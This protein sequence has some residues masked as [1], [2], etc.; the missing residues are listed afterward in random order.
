MG[1]GEAGSGGGVQ[2]AAGAVEVAPLRRRG[3]GLQAAFMK[4]GLEE[5][6]RIGFTRSLPGGLAIAAGRALPGFLPLRGSRGRLFR[7]LLL[8]PSFRDAV[9]GGREDVLSKDHHAAEVG[10][11]ERALLAGSRAAQL[12]PGI[13]VPERLRARR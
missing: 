6:L 10:R 3:G 12:Q 9:P 13:G 2:E 11:A 4:Q 5:E 1:A 8:E 7:I